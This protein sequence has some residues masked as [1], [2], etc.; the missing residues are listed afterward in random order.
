[1]LEILG[2]AAMVCVGLILGCIGSGGSILAIPILVYL[3][4]E[5]VEI[6]SAYS[7]FLVGVT[8][9]TGAILK[10]AEQFLDVRAAF[11]FGFPSI[12]TT[13][14]T[15]RWLIPHVPDRILDWGSFH[16]TKDHLLLLLL[17]SLMIV[18][19]GMMLRGPAK[20]VA[21]LKVKS[22][23]LIP[24]GFVVGL[25]SGFVG[26]GGGFLILPAMVL[27]ARLQVHAA[28]GTTLLIIASNS[29]LGFCGHVFTHSI[30]WYFL[31]SITGF[32]VVGLFLGRWADKRITA[33]FS[34]SRAFA[35]FTMAMG[36]LILVN[37]LFGTD[38]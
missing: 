18:S 27:F 32:A 5:D 4:S 10:Q 12:A 35:W 13:F 7:L 29:L 36:V 16:I 11:L 28:I 8:S 24:S 15:R 9:L 1:M 38:V 25:V 34:A 22:T 37:V 26:I 19:A 17:S 31:L 23:L 14:I 3:F 21:T 30:N 20:N 6:A 2:Y 33:P